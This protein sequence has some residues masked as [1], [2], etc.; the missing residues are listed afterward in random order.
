MAIGRIAPTTG[1]IIG[2]GITTPIATIAR[3]TTVTTGRI[4]TGRGPASGRSVSV[5]ALIA[6]HGAGYAP[7]AGPAHREVEYSNG[8][9]RTSRRTGVPQVDCPRAGKSADNPGSRRHDARDG[10]VRRGRG[11]DDFDWA[12]QLP[13]G[14]GFAASRRVGLR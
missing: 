8:W 13:V 5:E 14:S 2:T 4:T 3:T 11:P 9:T 6:G 10:N 1:T 7:V 12:A